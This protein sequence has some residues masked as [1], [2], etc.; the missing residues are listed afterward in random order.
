MSKRK[1][2]RVCVV[3]PAYN[4][5]SVLAEVLRNLPKLHHHQSFKINFTTVV[6]DD[7]SS[8]N[9]YQEAR[10]VEG[11]VALKHIINMGAGAA[12]RTGLRYAKEHGYDLA[13]TMDA[14]GQHAANDALGLIERILDEPE[15]DLLIGSRLKS[16]GNMPR[17]KKIGNKGL[18]YV[19]FLLLGT[20][21]SDSQSGLRVYS[22]KALE[23][24]SYHSNNYAFCSE[25]IW[26]AKRAG[27]RIAEH[28]I[29][30][31]YTEYSKQKGQKNFS[32]AMKILQQLVNRR[33]MDII[34]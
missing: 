25:M 33:I 34:Q 4:E 22:R 23:N 10:G 19:T 14:D 29:E 31:I 8:D 9:T 21:V 6:V 18:S 17:H 26:Q 28:P 27:L 12:T 32:G 5:A 15:L 16:D 7:G 11:V 2:I 20:Y 24:L 30:A 13:I 3:I 1:Q